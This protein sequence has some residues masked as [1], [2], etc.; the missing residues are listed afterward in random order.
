MHGICRGMVF[1]YLCTSRGRKNRVPFSQ[2]YSA[3]CLNNQGNDFCAISMS[4]AYSL[5][6]LKKVLLP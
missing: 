4:I 1:L 3:F 2:N 6:P 5:V